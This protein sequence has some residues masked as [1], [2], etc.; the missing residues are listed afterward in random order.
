MKPQNG[1]TSVI[2]RTFKILYT[3]HFSTF[4]YYNNLTNSLQEI[5]EGMT[6]FVLMCFF[7][8]ILPYYI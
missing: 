2:F 1:L 5:N 6:F 3:F 7:K 4:Y 8:A